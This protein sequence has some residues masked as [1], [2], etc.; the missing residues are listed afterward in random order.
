MPVEGTKSLAK[1]AS[2][3]FVLEWD[4]GL[5]HP[6]RVARSMDATNSSS[7]E[8]G[9]FWVVPCDPSG[10]RVHCVCVCVPIQEWMGRSSE[11]SSTT[12]T[13]F[14]QETMPQDGM[15]QRYSA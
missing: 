9:I 3:C 1:F 10:E 5:G 2:R 14:M 8:S 7:D 15:S 6:L 13:A 11:E 4:R 12:L